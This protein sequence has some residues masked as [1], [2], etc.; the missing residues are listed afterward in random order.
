MS[1]IMEYRAKV[2]IDNKLHAFIA[3]NG[4]WNAIQAWQI[5]K[6]FDEHD[7]LHIYEYSAWALA[8]IWNTPCL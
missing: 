2:I 8:V 3:E 1:N 6:W 5:R 7:N 4:G